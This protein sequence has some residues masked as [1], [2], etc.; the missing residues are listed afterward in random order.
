M[1]RR[2]ESEIQI[3]RS[4]YLA[5]MQR[6]PQIIVLSKNFDVFRQLQESLS[7]ISEIMVMNT[8]DVLKAK[9]LILE[10]GI[11]IIFVDES[12]NFNLDPL[13]QTTRYGKTFIIVGVK[14]SQPFWKN[15]KSGWGADYRIPTPI[16]KSH[17]L[18]IINRQFGS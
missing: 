10:Y 1:R 17:V 6:V 15:E 12:H 13:L 3:D 7:E 18:M 5:K 14:K 4:K 2:S 16:E 11:R 8:D 9:K